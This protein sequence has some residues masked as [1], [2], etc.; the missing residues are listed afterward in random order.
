M[1]IITGYTICGVETGLLR[2]WTY[3]SFGLMGLDEK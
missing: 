1:A 3:S 2:F